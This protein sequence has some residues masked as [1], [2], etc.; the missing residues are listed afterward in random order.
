MR[1]HKKLSLFILSLMLILGLGLALTKNAAPVAASSHG[2]KYGRVK[3]FT[4]PKN[5]RGTWY[6]YISKGKYAKTK[7]TTHKIN[8][9]TAYVQSNWWRQHS[10]L[11]IPYKYKFIKACTVK[12]SGKK[13][14]YVDVWVRDMGFPDY[15]GIFN[16]KVNGKKHKMMFA[17][18]GTAG[19]NHGNWYAKSKK[20][21]AHFKKLYY[22][23]PLS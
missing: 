4:F 3:K 18:V 19:A 21:A 11:A 10:K 14:V 12:L 13:Y 2:D 22:P 5:M 1:Q 9:K 23:N 16:K 15:Y 6:T 20:I 7:I 8:G 17:S